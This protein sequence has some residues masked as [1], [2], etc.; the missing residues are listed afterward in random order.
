MNE[1]ALAIADPQIV[2]DR[3]LSDTPTSVIAAEYGVTRQA[4]GKHLRKHALEDWQEAQ[5]ARASARKEQ[6]EEDLQS[7]RSGKLILENGE[8]VAADAVSLACARERLKAAQWDLERVCNRIYGQ[9]TQVTIE[10]VGDLGERLRKA[11]E[12]V[13]DGEC[14]NLG[15]EPSTQAIE[16]N[17]IVDATE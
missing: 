9:K 2:I 13:I 12:R 11:R 8:E 10:H 17:G 15:V 16:S 7:L 3:F 14:A 6:A 5:I 4:L 1:G